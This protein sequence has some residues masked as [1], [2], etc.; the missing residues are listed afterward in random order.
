MHIR[1]KCIFT[2]CVHSSTEAS[3]AATMGSGS[4][5]QRLGA[6]VQ[7]ACK[8]LA[9]DKQMQAARAQQLLSS[10][11][12]TLDVMVQCIA[13]SFENCSPF[14]DAMLLVAFEANPEETQR[15]LSKSCKKVLSAPISKAEYEW[16]K[17]CYMSLELGVHSQAVFRIK[18]TLRASGCSAPRMDSSCSSG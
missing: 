14:S 5:K 8:K 2:R 11:P 4:S 18:C 7:V 3:T 12:E 17:A 13:T 16:F 1:A 9:A 10:S 15:I 6:R